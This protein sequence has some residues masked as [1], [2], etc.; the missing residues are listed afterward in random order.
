MYFTYRKETAAGLKS[1]G[2][3]KLPAFF[4]F[5]IIY[6]WLEST[7]FLVVQPGYSLHWTLNSIS[8]YPTN[9]AHAALPSQGHLPYTVSPYALALN[10]IKVGNKH[11]RLTAPHS[12]KKAPELGRAAFR[13][14]CAHSSQ[15]CWAQRRLLPAQLLTI[16]R[17]LKGCSTTVS[18]FHWSNWHRNRFTSCR[19]LLS[20]PLSEKS[21]LK[22]SISF[23]RKLVERQQT[24]QLFPYS[25]VWF[26]SVL[27]GWGFFKATRRGEMVV[28]RK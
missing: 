24:F 15:R 23:A 7:V 2:W 10:S 1:E 4:A 27:K 5:C 14:W 9:K 17:V 6:F 25:A 11:P 18:H 3:V 20:Q 21:R 22:Y 28:R 19:L 13:S 12:R 16:P 26:S 8:T